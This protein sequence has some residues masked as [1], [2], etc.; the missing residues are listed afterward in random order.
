[1]TTP[2]W[3]QCCACIGMPNYVYEYPNDF[4]HERLFCQPV[5]QETAGPCGASTVKVRSMCLPF[6]VVVLPL[7]LVSPLLST[8]MYGMCH[9]RPTLLAPESISARIRFEFQP[10]HSILFVHASQAYMHVVQTIFGHV[11]S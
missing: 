1:M 8:N 9:A 2:A 7:V 4:P 5:L 10:E 11:K 6:A 3:G